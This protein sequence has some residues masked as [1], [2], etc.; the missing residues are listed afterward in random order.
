ME[1]K[2]TLIFGGRRGIGLYPTDTSC[3]ASIEL[4]VDGGAVQV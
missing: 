4:F 2:N 1:V 3:I